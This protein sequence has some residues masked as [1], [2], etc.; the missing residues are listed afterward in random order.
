[1]KKLFDLFP[2]PIF[3]VN[4]LDQF[5]DFEYIT[6]WLKDA[7]STPLQI[8]EG[9]AQ[10][11]YMESWREA[12]YV[13]QEIP[14]L[15]EALNGYITQ[16]CHLNGIEY[17]HLADSWYTI[18]NKGSRVT[19]HRHEANTISG[20]LY[21]NVPEGS[22]GLAFANPTIPYRMNERQNTATKYT[23][24]AHLVE[25]EVGDL[26]LYPSW[27]E[28]FVPPIECDNRVSISFNADYK[29]TL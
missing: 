2:T 22:H 15:E 8:V 1:M 14:E 27:I 20:T 25:V 24:Y 7:V 5:D 9:D 19:R 11:C 18:M 21:V 4:V 6:N 10:T 28:H 26:L 13:L 17:C 29:R 23:E 16:Y 12:S 3:K